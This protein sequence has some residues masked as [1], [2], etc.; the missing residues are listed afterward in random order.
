MLW[1][2]AA[3]VCLIAAMLVSV[4]T[5]R[6]EPPGGIYRY[7][8]RHPVYGRIGTYT[9]VIERS[10]PGVE[11]TTRIG[12]AVRFLF[13]VVYRLE[14]VRRERWRDGRLTA[15]ESLTDDN[16]RKTRITGHAEGE[17]FIIETPSGR[18]VAPGGVFPTNPWSVRITEAPATIA[19]E[20]GVLRYATATGG[21]V[22]GI[23]LGGRERKA[24]RYRITGDMEHEI[25]F[26]ED[27][28][29]VKFTYGTDNG[30]IVFSLL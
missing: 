7:E 19:A 25:W 18:I 17:R 11:V 10:G 27:D 15:Y 29:P 16:G 30:T 5:A 22:E 4:D 24:R 2:N 6:A 21:D 26:D 9:N 23:S 12:V 28:I 13:V 20:T 1:R 14:A 3:A 8:I